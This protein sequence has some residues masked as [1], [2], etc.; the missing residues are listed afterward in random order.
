MLYAP[1]ELILSIFLQILSR[2]NEYAADRFA[3]ET[4]EDAEEM[5]RGLKNLA[6]DNLSNVTPHPFYVFLN[7]SHP[8]DLERIRAIR[9]LKQ[10]VGSRKS[11]KFPKQR[12]YP[13]FGNSLRS[14]PKQPTIA[15]LKVRGVMSFNTQSW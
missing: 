9:S 11:S 10:G 13:G 5:V 3:A 12:A 8:P 2:R 6:R 4:I 1:L 14:F 15:V 7:Y